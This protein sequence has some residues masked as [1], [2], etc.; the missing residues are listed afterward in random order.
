VVKRK[1]PS[2]RRESNLRN[3]IVQ[4]VLQ[5]VVVVVVVVMKV[6]KNPG[7]VRLSDVKIQRESLPLPLVPHKPSRSYH[8]QY[9]V[10]STISEVDGPFSTQS[11]SLLDFHIFGGSKVTL[12][13]AAGF[14][15]RLQRC[16]RR[17]SSSLQFHRIHITVTAIHH[18]RAF[19][20]KFPDNNVTILVEK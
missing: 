16:P 4:P 5:V 12:K 10:T 19:L 1:I 7:R 3:P 15:R 14:T 2:P 17:V 8:L 6:Y 11:G 20:L 9:C 13:R 18:S